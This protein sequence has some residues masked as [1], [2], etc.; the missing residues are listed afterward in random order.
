M[1]THCQNKTIWLPSDTAMVPPHMLTDKGVSLCRTEQQPGQ[2]VVIFPRA[3]TSSIATGY[4]ISESV[5]FAT[6]KWLDSSHQDF[7]VKLH[8]KKS[9]RNGKMEFF[10]CFF[11]VLAGYSGKL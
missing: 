11:F 8:K 5:Y 1:P 4:V 2:F 3:Y 10:V 7:K 6:H 9:L